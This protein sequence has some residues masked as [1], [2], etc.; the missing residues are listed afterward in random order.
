[1]KLYQ[2]QLLLGLGAFFGL[3]WS[4]PLVPVEE[5]GGLSGLNHLNNIAER[6]PSQSSKCANTCTSA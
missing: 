6:Q 1:M 2:P 3:S 5:D 4:S